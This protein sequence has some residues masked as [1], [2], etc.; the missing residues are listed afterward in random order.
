[1]GVLVVKE[2]KGKVGECWGRR[3]DIADGEGRE[4]CVRGC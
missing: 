4:D 2:V 3:V 1:M